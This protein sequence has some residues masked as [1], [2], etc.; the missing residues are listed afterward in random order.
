MSNT[1]IVKIEALKHLLQAYPHLELAILV[2]SRALNTVTQHSD[3]DIAIRWKKGINNLALLEQAEALK[4]KIAEAIAI[5][6][7]QIDLIDMT[8]ARL[9]MRAV[10]AEEGVML[11]GDDTLAWSHFLTQTWGE[12]EDYYWR[13]HHAA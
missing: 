10:I 6:P 5:H 9:A 3:W 11:K 2:G 7:D 12:L 1:D 8:T 13:K 4:Q